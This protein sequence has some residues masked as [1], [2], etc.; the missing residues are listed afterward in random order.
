MGMD[1]TKDQHIFIDREEEISF[2]EEKWRSRKPQLIVI[3]GKRRVGKTEL[4]RRFLEGRPHLYFLAE[5]T[6]DRDQLERFSRAVGELFQEPLLETRG[7]SSWEE[8][9]R[10]LAR[11]RERLALV[12]DEFPYLIQANRGITTLFQR[13]WDEELS[14]SRLFL[15][16]M[17]SSV[18]MMES[19]VLGYRAPLYGRRTG[20]WKVQPLSFSQAS[21]FRPGRPFEDRVMHYA[22][23]G[24]IPAYWT[25]FSPRKDFRRNLRD[26]VLRKGEFLYDEVEFILRE[27][28]REPRFYFSIL[29][30]MAQGKR[31][32]SEITNATGIPQPTANKYLGVLI[33]LDIVEREVPATEE[34]PAKSKK[35]LYRIRDQFFDFWF[36]FVLPRRGDLEMGRLDSACDR[37]MGELPQYLGG[38]YERIAMETLRR[39][40]K[41]LFTFERLGRWWDRNREIDILALNR[42][43]NR[44]LVAEVKWSERPV[45]V[46]VYRGLRE[47]AEAAFRGRFRP[48]IDYVLFSQKGFTPGM[49]KAARAENILLFRGTDPVR[50]P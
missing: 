31:R 23:A 44:A 46:E 47:K 34:K 16:L 38:V 7:F 49:L 10:F 40:E 26:H 30:A 33:D 9:L 17:G 29:Q 45:G 20:Q 1:V 35:G 5:S 13:L 22:V 21:L 4:V 32:I 50:H 15:V 27:E 48:E 25:L 37:I 2:L 43:E 42:E 14:R 12:L 6:N 24:G 41:E 39:H 18:G 8:G 3:W 36:R 11:R 19:E 28:L